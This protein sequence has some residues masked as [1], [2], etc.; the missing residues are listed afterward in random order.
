MTESELYKQCDEL[1]SSFL[2]P[3]GFR[4]GKPGEYLRRTQ[5]GEDRIL[6][7]RGPSSK[8]KTHFAVFMSYEPDY[9]MKTIN[10]LISYGGEDRGFSCGPYLNPVGVTPRPKY[11]SYRDADALKRSVAHVIQCLEKTGLPWLESL[12]DPKTF[13][14]NVDPVAALPAGLANEIAG[15]IE[16]AK[17]FYNEMLRRYRLSSQLLKDEDEQ[18]QS[19]GKAFV[20]VASKLDVEQ[21]RREAFKRK[22][23]YYPE[24]RPLGGS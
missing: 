8:A 14:S 19:F 10:E 16:I 21:E 22:L 6:V 15:N 23:N 1:L 24:I 18:L 17:E 5:T 11:W 13:A 12:R 2:N 3:H 9:L 7:S 4:N 20:F